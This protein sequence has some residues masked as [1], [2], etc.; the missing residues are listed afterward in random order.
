MRSHVDIATRTTTRVPLDRHEAR[1]LDTQDE[2]GVHTVLAGEDVALH[3][4]AMDPPVLLPPSRD[5][6]HRG[7]IAPRHFTVT[8]AGSVN[9]ERDEISAPKLTAESEV[10]AVWVAIATH[11]VS[12]DRA[13]GALLG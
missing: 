4:P 8:V 3:R 7:R 6:N 13:C 2:S 11:R 5:V 9:A 1:A 10:A 12:F